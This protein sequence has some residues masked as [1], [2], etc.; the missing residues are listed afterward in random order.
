[1]DEKNLNGQINVNEKI[2][3]RMYLVSVMIIIAITNIN[4]FFTSIHPAFHIFT[5]FI[6]LNLFYMFTTIVVKNISLKVDSTFIVFL[7]CLLLYISIGTLQSNPIDNMGIALG[8]VQNVSIVFI[9]I[10]SIKKE[11]EYREF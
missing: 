3:I 7:M 6:I 11:Y 1:M 9:L 10:N 2:G 5:F 4:R 8:I